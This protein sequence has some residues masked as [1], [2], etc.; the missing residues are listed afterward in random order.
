VA[1][2]V[3]SVQWTIE[4][5]FINPALSRRTLQAML[6]TDARALEEASVGVLQ[7]VTDSLGY[8]FLIAFLY[9]NGLLLKHLCNPASFSAEQAARITN[10]AVR[11][12]SGFAVSLAER[13]VHSAEGEEPLGEEAENRTMEILSM[14]ARNQKLGSYFE[15]LV[16]HPNLGIQSKAA[17]LAG[18]LRQ[19]GEWARQ[20]LL[21]PESR[22]RANAVESLWTKDPEIA[23]PILW[24]A[25]FD[26]NNRVE[27]NALHGLLRLRDPRAIP[28]LH[29]MLTDEGETRRHTGLWVL[30][31]NPDPRFIPVL[32]PAIGSARDETRKRLFATLKAMKGARDAVIARGQVSV[33]ILRTAR[34]DTGLRKA[35]VLCRAG[36]RL[37]TGTDLTTLDLSVVDS[38]HLVASYEMAQ[39]PAPSKLRCGLL[40]PR[41]R[42]DGAVRAA[43]DR[44]AKSLRNG[45][46]AAVLFFD[47]GVVKNTPPA[48]R[49]EDP[50]LFEYGP[51]FV[52]DPAQLRMQFALRRTGGAPAGLAE[53]IPAGVRAMGAAGGN[54]I[55]AA[56]PGLEEPGLTEALQSSVKPGTAIH[57]I[58]PSGVIDSV[59]GPLAELAAATGGRLFRSDREED[60]AEGLQEF[61]DGLFLPYE[62]SWQE[63]GA[64]GFKIQIYSSYGHG[65]AVWPRP[66]GAEAGAAE[67]ESK[68]VTV[69]CR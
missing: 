42:S 63:G 2:P 40:A 20:C 49:R 53:A 24:D 12:Q 54:L 17:L 62:I 37:L 68:R 36:S 58:L 22:V 52:K 67:D 6:S 51:R 9:N 11:V 14:L 27:G 3:Q 13:L 56:V 10:V 25:A 43:V 18:Q 16:N 39:A 46:E 61:L 32:A 23:R 57:A 45:D 35:Y 41:T 59:A 47:A 15:K 33:E 21:N 69:E 60:L 28:L 65:E 44:L 1:D 5:F 55:V 4:N 8:Q 26:G 48:P 30:G 66:A 64:S 38:G 7:E 50:V 31:R 34:T 29:K 19:D